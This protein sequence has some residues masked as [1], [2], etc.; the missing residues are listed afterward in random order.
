MNPPFRYPSRDAILEDSSALSTRAGR[1]SGQK[2]PSIH[3]QSL[4]TIRA[5]FSCSALKAVKDDI[6]YECDDFH[7]EVELTASVGLWSFTWSRFLPAMATAMTLVLLATSFFS[8]NVA[9]SITN[10]NVQGVIL[11]QTGSPFPGADVTVEIWGGYWPDQDYFRT[12]VSTVT[13][14]WGYYE[15]TINSNYWDPHNTIKLVVTFG[16]SQDTHKVEANDEQYQT[17]DMYTS[18]VIPEFTGSVSLLVLLT[19]SLVSGAIFLA[20]R[21][22]MGGGVNFRD[23]D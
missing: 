6:Y 17:V 11:N 18:I 3:H 1:K 15:V 16:S 21:R 10:K 20:R 2:S 19:G 4:A 14:A 23:V 5:V 22:K 9:G 8:T 13:D 12:S 7:Y